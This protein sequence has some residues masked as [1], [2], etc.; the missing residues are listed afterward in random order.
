MRRQQAPS[1]MR[2]RDT[3]ACAT[4]RWH[5]LGYFG[6]FF[7]MVDVGSQFADRHLVGLDEQYVHQVALDGNRPVF[8]CGSR[9]LDFI[10][11]QYAAADVFQLPTAVGIQNGGFGFCRLGQFVFI[12][13]LPNF[14]AQKRMV[15]QHF[16][17]VDDAVFSFSQRPVLPVLILPLMAAALM[18]SAF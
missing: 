14:D 12:V 6:C 16:A 5:R 17:H 13:A 10:F 11:A 8:L 7:Q 15:G 9:N 2:Q 3:P 18:F 4:M 1:P